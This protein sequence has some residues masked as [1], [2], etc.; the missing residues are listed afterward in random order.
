MK[1]HI[2]SI[3]LL[4]VILFA[5]MQMSM[6]D[7]DMYGHYVSYH[8]KYD[9]PILKGKEKE[10]YLTI[11]MNK[12]NKELENLGAAKRW[13]LR[14]VTEMWDRGYQGPPYLESDDFVRR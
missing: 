8:D 1:F 12:A 5:S 4:V 3:F 9:L 2:S 7:Y 11:I 10:K 14:E 6:A 13:T